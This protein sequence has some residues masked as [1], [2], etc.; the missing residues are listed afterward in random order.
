MDKCN[1]HTILRLPTGIFYAQ[2]VKT[3]V[4][5]F[6]QGKKEKGNTQEVWVYDM[7]ANMPQ[8]GKRTQLTRSHFAEFEAAFGDDPLGSP[9]SLAKRRDTGD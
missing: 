8:F 6:T 5:Y 3:N 2:G 4:L 1:L 7:R 9:A